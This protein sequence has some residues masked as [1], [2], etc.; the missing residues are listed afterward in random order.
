MDIISLCP[1][2]VG[3][4]TWQAHTGAYALTVVVKATF[5]LEQDR[6]VLAPDQE[7]VLDQE[8][9]WDADPKRSVYAPSDRAPYKARADVMLVGHA[10]AP[11]GQPVRS[12]VARMQ[13]GKIDKSIE[14]WCDR[15]FRIHDHQ[16]LEGP[17]FVTMPLAWERAAG[18]PDN[19]AGM[20]FDATPDR[21]G[22]VAIPNLQ[23]VGLYVA[24]RSDTFAAV[25]FGPVRSTWPARVQK[26]G[27]HASAFRDPGWE[28]WALPA[29][30]DV[31]YFQAAPPDQ[32]V[33]EI[34]PNESIVLENLHP[35]HP[36]L[37]TALPGIR[38]RAIVDRATGEREEV[39]LVGDTLWIDTDRRL[40]CVVWRGR[41]GLRYAEEAGRIAVWVDG[42]PMVDSAEVPSS[43]LN[44]SVSEGEADIA[45][46]TLVGSFVAKGEPTLPFAPGISKLP[47]GLAADIAQWARMTGDG[48]GT[49][50]APMAEFAEKTLPFRLE[51]RDRKDL[52]ETIPPPPQA[53]VAPP[54]FIHSSADRLLEVEADEPAPAR[55]NVAPPPMIGPLATVETARNVAEAAPV[56]QEPDAPEAAGNDGRIEAAEDVVELSIEE[57]ATIAAEIAEG[58]ME[59]T[60]VLEAHSLSERAW[61]KNEAR[62]DAAMEEEQG[63]GRNTLRGAYDAAYVKRVEGYRGTIAVEEYARLVVG[64]ERGKVE[65]ALDGLAIQRKALMPIV[66][67]WARKVARDANVGAKMTMVLRETRLT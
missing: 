35:E 57:T 39:A 20:S 64:L 65:E 17:R 34:Q 52:A 54:P 33:E 58:Q 15:G 42:M 51:A 27:P 23:P 6:A 56:L 13:V 62:W 22:M 19:P 24:R 53:G 8:Q 30:I 11:H 5:R 16:L 31:G 43:A 26:V 48:T 37:I 21:Y 1:L 50:M 29:E 60:K 59:R 10:Y 63:R 41:I 14:V 3:C 55:V 46:M 9:T 25:G 67:L 28:K 44:L 61:G 12:L 18:G 40:C 7:R 49:M 38:P 45:T 47:E 36:R 66:R 2:R 32:Q 4:F